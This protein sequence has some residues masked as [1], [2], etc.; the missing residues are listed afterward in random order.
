M[1][2][3]HMETDLIRDAGNHL[4]Q[5]SV[6]L[7]EKTQQISHSIQ[8]L[9]SVWQ[10]TSATIF[11][12]E[13]Q[14]LLQQ[15]QQLSTAGEMFNKRLQQEVN[16]WEQIANDL[17]GGASVV[18]AV[19]PATGGG[20][21]LGEQTSAFAEQYQN[22]TWPQK[23]D[24][25]EQLEQKIIELEKEVN[26]SLLANRRINEIDAE[27]ARL[28]AEMADVKAE[29]DTWY[30]K[31]IPTLPIQGDEDGVPWRVR[32]DN[33]E[34]TIAVYEQQLQ[35]LRSEKN[36]FLVVQ[37]KQNQLVQLGLERDALQTIITDHQNALL[38]TAENVPFQGEGGNYPRLPNTGNCT[39][40]AAEAM[41]YASDGKID[42]TQT[43][44]PGWGNA[45]NWP[46]AANT[47]LS[48]NPNGIVNAINHVPE[49]GSI[50][51]LP[52]N[53]VAFVES[54]ELTPDGNWQIVFSEENASG[55]YNTYSG[56]QGATQVINN[57]G[58][59][60]RWRHTVIW[61]EIKNTQFIH[62]NY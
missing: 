27:I 58:S 57:P 34:D 20:D 56:E 9:S 16:E 35:A 22:L 24:E 50:A 11:I 4:Q 21:V 54:A 61:G 30:N 15:L 55:S 41:K 7:Q 19:L 42:I 43:P 12:G 18:M 53:H 36:D 60:T 2:L 31:V 10:G 13:I 14:P 59:S 8:N 1:P 37:G 25:L 29:A 17:M 33:Y 5:T 40:Y 45:S 52:P 51:F 46:S 38:F 26:E 6:S 3:L 44:F 23:F 49:A 28:E 47:Y 39:W 48:E 62:F 32:T